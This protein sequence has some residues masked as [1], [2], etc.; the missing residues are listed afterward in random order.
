MTM[1]HRRRNLFIGLAVCAAIAAAFAWGLSRLAIDNDVVK[2]VPTRG[3]VPTHA[4]AVLAENRALDQV[5][6]DLSMADGS[7]ARDSLVRAADTVR[8]RL[9]DTGLFKSVGVRGTSTDMPRLVSKVASHLPAMFDA[10][11]LTRLDRELFTEEGIDDALDTMM[12]E[13]SGLSGV[14]QSG[15]Y[16]KDPLGLRNRVL[17]RFS[18]SPFFENARPYKGHLLSRDGSHLLIP[19][20][21]AQSGTDTGYARKLVALLDGLAEDLKDR[22]VRL[23]HMGAYR[24]ALD[25]EMIV[26]RDATFAMALT[27][28]GVGILLLAGFP[29]PWIGLL[30]L[31]PAVFGA[32]AA[33]FVYSLLRDSITGLALGFGGALVSI[34]VDHSIAYLLYLD[35][36]HDTEARHASHQVWSVGLF[37]VITTVGA[38]GLLLFSGFP[39]MAQVGLFAALGIAFS[40]VF[41]HTVFPLLIPGLPPAKRHPPVPLESWLARLC[42]NRGMLAAGL[43]LGLA[44]GAVFLAQ[45]RFSVDV[46]EMNTV[47]PDTEQAQQVVAETWGDVESQVAVMVRAEDPEGLR[48]EADKVAALWEN[49]LE[50]GVLDSGLVVGMILPGPALADAHKRA[51]RNFWTPEKVRDVRDRFATA[52]SSRG[53]VAGAFSPFWDMLEHPGHGAPDLPR[54]LYPLFGISGGDGGEPLVLMATARRGNDYDPGEFFQENAATGAKVLDPE[55]FARR[56]SGLLQSTFVRMLTWIAVAVLVLF[57]LLFFEWRLVLACAAPVAFALVCTLATLNLAGRPIDIPGLM[58]G[59][60]V[61]GM[62]VDY[63]IF[64]VRGQQR[65][66]SARHPAQGPIRMAVFLAGSSTLVGMGVLAFSEHAVLRSVGTTAGLAIL[67]SLLGT[68]VILP[69]VLSRLFRQKPFAGGGVGP[70][71]PEHL[72]RAASRYALL[73]PYPR[74]FAWFKM[75]TDPMFDRLADLAPESGTVWDAGCGYAVPAVWLAALRPGLRF[76][77]AEPDPERVRVAR[78]TLGERGRVLQTDA[79]GLSGAPSPDCVLFLDVAHHLDDDALTGFLNMCADRLAKG[80]RLVMRTTVTTDKKLPWERILERLRV[81]RKKGSLSFRKPEVMVD[82]LRGAGF[83]VENVAPTAPGREEYWFIGVLEH[84]GT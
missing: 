26:R 58:L 71:S 82:M 62:G 48:A 70:G 33:L 73:E 13:L 19:A 55:L 34:T 24:A 43:A 20:V 72:L 53:M 27:T 46:S 41:V 67:Y 22:G 49:Y 78:R 23:V 65:Y 36:T 75:R 3:P 50:R 4:R 42:A 40:F 45:P 16:T 2:A 1:E 66:F 54:S 64:F 51:W 28:I 77:G 38:F 29:R 84:T 57:T 35:R 74:L 5:V 9:E 59:V 81:G 8:Q 61:F 18:R 17:A 21:P 11:D 39:L 79:S 7:V 25:N 31:V 6:I 37:A 44:G 56:L 63:G 80:G 32:M 76:I 83:M 10:D 52:A 68:F 15:L 60:V 30:A 69:P 47:G 14:G 12:R